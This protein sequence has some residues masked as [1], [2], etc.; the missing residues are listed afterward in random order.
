MFPRADRPD[1]LAGLFGRHWLVLGAMVPIGPL[2]NSQ[3]GRS[4]STAWWRRA[5]SVASA[6][7]WS[8]KTALPR[9]KAS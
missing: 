5:N 8:A 7:Q 1:K 9:T 3:V 4:A 2:L 6:I